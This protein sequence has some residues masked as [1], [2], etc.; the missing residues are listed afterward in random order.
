MTIN[1]DELYHDLMEYW[2]HVEQGFVINAM[3]DVQKAWE[4]QDYEAIVAWAI[5]EGFNLNDYSS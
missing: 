1:F 2:T 4:K 5:Q 3:I